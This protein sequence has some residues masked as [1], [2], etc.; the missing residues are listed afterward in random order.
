MS[1][2]ITLEDLAQMVAEGFKGVAKRLEDLDRKQHERFTDIESRLGR[3][4][5]RFGRIEDK[6]T[7]LVEKLDAEQA[8]TSDL[9]DNLEPRVAA[10]EAKLP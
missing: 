9:R 1:K 7:E 4:E 5:N 2:D 6:L 10:L 3:L 8:F